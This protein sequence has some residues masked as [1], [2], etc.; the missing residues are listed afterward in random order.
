MFK[1][2]LKRKK[3]LFQMIDTMLQDFPCTCV[4]LFSI[5]RTIKKND[6]HESPYSVLL[7][8]I[9]SLLNASFNIHRLI[10][11]HNQKNDECTMQDILEK[12]PN[13]EKIQTCSYLIAISSAMKYMSSQSIKM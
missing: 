13:R 7:A 8:V 4:Q 1:I 12:S 3:S 10:Y 5:F 6:D 9:V 2:K 11:V